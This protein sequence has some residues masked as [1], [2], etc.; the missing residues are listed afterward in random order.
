[1]ATFGVSILVCQTNAEVRFIVDLDS[2]VNVLPKLDH[3]FL[4]EPLVFL[5]EL[6]VLLIPLRALEVVAFETFLDIDS[7]LEHEP[8]RIHLKQC[9]RHRFR[10]CHVDELLPHSRVPLLKCLVVHVLQVVCAG[11]KHKHPTVVAAADRIAVKLSNLLEVDSLEELTILRVDV[12]H[13]IG[14]VHANKDSQVFNTIHFIHLLDFDVLFTLMSLHLKCVGIRLSHDLFICLFVEFVT[15]CG[16]DIQRCQ[17]VF[18]VDLWLAK[19]HSAL[20][21]VWSHT[22]QRWQ[23]LSL[24]VL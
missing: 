10:F 4:K 20:V 18:L 8:S 24:G 5:F 9:E 7:F 21:E 13:A 11:A 22:H 23:F 1:M 15:A 14:D 19:V 17:E 16:G 3:V 2:Q 12:I 6:I